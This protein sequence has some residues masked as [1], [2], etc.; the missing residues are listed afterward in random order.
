MTA[1]SLWK[2]RLLRK[3]RLGYFDGGQ[4]YVK[5]GSVKVTEG[6]ET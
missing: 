4:F 1:L 3:S 2:W 6:G 5:P